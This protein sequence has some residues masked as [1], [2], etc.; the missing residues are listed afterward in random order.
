MCEVK[1][2]LILED[3]GSIVNFYE[4]RSNIHL[5]FIKLNTIF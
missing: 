1:T 5:H 2:E 4:L 3:G